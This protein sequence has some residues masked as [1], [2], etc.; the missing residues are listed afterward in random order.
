MTVPRILTENKDEPL[1]KGHLSINIQSI[2][3]T[4]EAGTCFTLEPYDRWEPRF[5]RTKYVSHYVEW[6]GTEMSLEYD[7]IDT[8]TEI[9]LM[10]YD[11]DKAKSPVGALWL[12]L[13]DILHS[14]EATEYQDDNSTIVDTWFILAPKGKVRLKLVFS[15]HVLLHLDIKQSLL[16][17]VVANQ[18]KFQPKN[19]KWNRLLRRK[20][21]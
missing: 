3:G 16:F 9:E 5:I 18:G 14:G 20:H 17:P 15:K 12:R 4:S 2:T 7:D 11:N 1:L 6:T 19:Q 21:V 10:I 8:R 13:I